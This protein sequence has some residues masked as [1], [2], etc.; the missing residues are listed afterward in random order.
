MT[1]AEIRAAELEYCRD[2]TVYFIETYCHI[3]DKDRPDALIQPFDLWPMQK[4]A[5]ESI[6]QNRKNVIL[7]ARQLGFSWLVISYASKKMLCQTGR[8]VIGLSRTEAEAQEL[9]RRMEI[10]FRYMPELIADAKDVPPGWAGPV[11][12]KKSMELSIKF[13]DGPDSV[14]KVFPSS[15]GAARSFT[16]DLLIFDEW[17]FQQFAREIWASAF[18]TINRPM[19]G[20]VIGLSTIERGSL[21]EEIFT[22]PDTGFTKIFIPWYADPTLD[23]AWYQE[24]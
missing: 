15:P 16:A 23:S 3:E 13:P 7:K 20:Q 5:I 17:A 22:D 12:N 21:F 8:T 18:P 10:E 9:V 19:G 4:E 11:Y 1:A 2:H 6:E 24:T 14:F